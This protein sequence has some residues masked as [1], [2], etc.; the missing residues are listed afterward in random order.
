MLRICSFVDLYT[1][2]PVCVDNLLIVHRYGDNIRKVWELRFQDTK[3]LAEVQEFFLCIYPH[4]QLGGAKRVVNVYYRGEL[5]AAGFPD[6]DPSGSDAEQGDEASVSNSTTSGSSSGASSSD[7]DE[8]LESEAEAPQDPRS[9][10][11]DRRRDSQGRQDASSTDADAAHD[12]VNVSAPIV[13]AKGCTGKETAV[14]GSRRSVEAAPATAAAPNSASSRAAAKT[15]APAA[16][17][18]PVAAPAPVPAAVDASR[19]SRKRASLP[20]AKEDAPAP[21]SAE[22]ATASAQPAA[23]RSRSAPAPAVVPEPE[24]GADSAAKKRRR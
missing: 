17:P 9:A 21:A 13:A 11:R 5:A 14:Q 23:G 10:A 16:P 19:S 20:A 1:P 18:A 6:G 7:D 22:V 8:D 3:K 15:S 24:K 2:L 4:T 12:A